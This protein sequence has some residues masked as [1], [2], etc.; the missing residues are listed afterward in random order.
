M[1]NYIYILL[2]NNLFYFALFHFCI[3]NG[4]TQDLVITENSIDGFI[5]DILKDKR[6][7]YVYS[8]RGQ[9]FSDFYILDNNE[10]AISIY[11]SNGEIT[12]NGT[13]ILFLDNKNIA[14]D[15]LFILGWPP[16]GNPGTFSP[17]S[18]LDG[19]L[20]FIP[21][22][23][24]PSN[25]IFVSPKKPTKGYL[26]GLGNKN[27]IVFH[28]FASKNNLFGEYFDYNEKKEILTFKKNEISFRNQDVF[29][30][31]KEDK[32]MIYECKTNEF[33]LF[34]KSSGILEERFSFSEKDLI[35]FE[36]I[37]Q[38]LVIISAKN[39]ESFDF[40]ILVLNLDSKEVK[41]IYTTK[42]YIPRVKSFDNAIYFEIASKFSDSDFPESILFQIKMPMKMD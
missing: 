38:D 27:N 29:F 37:A 15:S 7:D 34:Q 26:T 32:I 21:L 23:V 35:N 20:T 3:P 36:L 22:M 31:H 16:Y 6:V 12:S 28:D 39:K 41:V 33:F 19:R 17:L 24:Y 5:Q 13:P 8:K 30:R 40:E 9:I 14:K 10:K 1:K 42:S 25:Q 11:R 2:K 4:Y 18:S